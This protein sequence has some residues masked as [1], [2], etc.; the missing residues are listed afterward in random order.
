MDIARRFDLKRV[1]GCGAAMGAEDET[2]A[3]AA[4]AA[5]VEEKTDAA[6]AAGGDA[7]ADDDAGGINLDVTSPRIFYPCMQCA[8]P[9]FLQADICHVAAS[10][11]SVIAMA[12]DYTQIPEVAQLRALPR[13]VMAIYES[14]TSL[15]GPQDAGTDPEAVIFMD[16]D[17]AD[18]K[19]KITRAFCPPGQIDENPCLELVRVIVLPLAGKLEIRRSDANGGNMDYTAMADVTRDFASG[20]L[21][22]GDLKPAIIGAINGINLGLIPVYALIITDFV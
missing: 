2:P 16:D 14:L 22:P 11:R 15:K 17:A 20:A 1:L 7:G 4:A 10:Q 3:A 21:H 19:K 8:I 13:P 6:V 18:V 5:A 12:Q 9:F